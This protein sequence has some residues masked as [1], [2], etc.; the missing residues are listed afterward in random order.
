MAHSFDGIMLHFSCS[1]LL[2][3]ASTLPVQQQFLQSSEVLTQLL[4]QHTQTWRG[5]WV[6]FA[7]LHH[8]THSLMI[9]HHVQDCISMLS[10]LASKK[11]TSFPSLVPETHQ[12][13]GCIKHLPNGD[14]HTCIR[15][16]RISASLA[17]LHM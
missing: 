7:I 6:P 17:P 10:V 1:I 13:H 12:L 8:G 15:Y 4:A 14:H 11:S 5:S 9:M 16:L 2:S 3:N